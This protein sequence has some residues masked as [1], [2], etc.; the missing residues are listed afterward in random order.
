MLTE[1]DKKAIS[2]NFGHENVS[3]TFD[4]YGYNTMTYDEVIETIKKLKNSQGDSRKN[5]VTD[6][7]MKIVQAA[8]DIHKRD[9]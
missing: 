2:L 4:S 6:A 5:L 8:R 9:N 7:E 1:K 3:T